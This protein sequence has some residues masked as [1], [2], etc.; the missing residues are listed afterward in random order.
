M[1]LT[2]HLG[3][4]VLH[5]HGTRLSTV[6]ALCWALLK[7]WLLPK[8][9]LIPFEVLYNTSCIIN[10]YFIHS[11][12]SISSQGHRFLV[13]SWLA[14]L[15]LSRDSCWE[16]LQLSATWARGKTASLGQAASGC[17]VG[18]GI[19]PCHP[20]PGLALALPRPIQVLN[21]AWRTRCL[22]F[23]EHSLAQEQWLAFLLSHFPSAGVP[24]GWDNRREVQI[25]VDSAGLCH[26]HP[27][28]LLAGTSTDSPSS[29]VPYL[30]CMARLMGRSFH[31]SGFSSLQSRLVEF[32]EATAK[33]W[34]AFWDLQV[35]RVVLC[36]TQTL[37]FWWIRINLE[38]PEVPSGGLVVRFGIFKDEIP[39]ERHTYDPVEALFLKSSRSLGS[40]WGNF[41]P[42]RNS[43][44]FN[45]R[46]E[47]NNSYQLGICPL[48]LSKSYF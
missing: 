26:G 16:G 20:M 27:C 19:F 39:L 23:Q 45:R 33:V 28:T 41:C 10:L 15:L 5:S 24:A 18:E 48:I 1:D 14:Q 43:F 22:S 37:W 29:P 21:N 7:I 40:L 36:P 13:K 8:W 35:S 17:R 9:E 32:Q 11:G 4:Q 6:Q 46:S 38:E 31:Y 3:L 42:G 12:K 44:H 30:A 47:A 2:F 25:N 34:D